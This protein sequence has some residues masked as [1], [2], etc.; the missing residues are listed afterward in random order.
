MPGPAHIFSSYLGSLA[1]PRSWRGLSQL[2]SEILTR[3]LA[4]GGFKPDAVWF[5]VP[6]GTGQDEHRQYTP[7]DPRPP[8]A[9]PSFKRADIVAAFPDAVYIV[10][11]KPA[12]SYVALGQITLYTDLA[13]EQWPELAD[14]LPAVLTDALDPDARASYEASGIRV[15]E[16]PGARHTPLGR[17]T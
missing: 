5:Y 1:N 17:P 8:E 9:E 2:D 15:L 6:L 11:I 12:A 4:S 13:R 10:E 16:L 14:A 7:T 3:H